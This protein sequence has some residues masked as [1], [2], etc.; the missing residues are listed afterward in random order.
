VTTFQISTPVSAATSTAEDRIPKLPLK[1][2]RWPSNVLVSASAM[3]VPQM[4]ELIHLDFGTDDEAPH[5]I[6]VLA[7]NT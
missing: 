4:D 2:S 6:A 1:P 7:R 5:E 3:S